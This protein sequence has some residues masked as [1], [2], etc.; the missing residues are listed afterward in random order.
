M[1]LGCSAKIDAPTRTVFAC[2]DEP[3]H[4]VRWVGGAVEH[5]YLTERS[6]A[7]AVGQRFRQRLRQ[8]R[9]I[10][11]FDGEI[12]AWE[13]A[14][15]FGLRIPTPAY[16][17]EAHFRISPSG[18]DR[19]TVDYSIDVALH[20]PLAKILGPLLSIP[21]R[22]FVRRQIASLKAYAETAHVGPEVRAR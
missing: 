17:S 2:V 15:H 22:L 3:Q 6:P 12:I 19:S 14:T 21:L 20:S 16:T 9:S 5:V 11:T 1:L 13:P 7:T 4:I 10:R 8:G 18:A